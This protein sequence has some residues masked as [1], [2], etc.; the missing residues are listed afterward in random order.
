MGVLMK[1]LL[2]LSVL[3]LFVVMNGAMDATD[4]PTSVPAPG[5]VGGHGG[6]IV[7]T[8]S[9]EPKQP[10][11]VS[12]EFEILGNNKSYLNVLF[13]IT[14]ADPY[15]TGHATNLADRLKTQITHRPGWTQRVFESV[16]GTTGWVIDR[17]ICRTLR[18]GLGTVQVAFDYGV[19][20]VASGIAGV[21]SWAWDKVTKQITTKRVVITLALLATIIGVLE[22]LHR[23]EML[24]AD[25]PYTSIRDLEAH[26]AYLK[27]LLDQAY[28]LK[29][30]LMSGC[31]DTFT[32]TSDTIKALWQKV[33]SINPAM[34][35]SYFQSIWEAITNPQQRLSQEQISYINSLKA[36][37]VDSTV[38]LSY[39]QNPLLSVDTNPLHQTYITASSA[40]KDTV[41][42]CKAIQEATATSGVLHTYGWKDAFAKTCA[43]YGINVF[44]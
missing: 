15:N 25:N 23:N 40:M 31:T 7:P 33:A 39:R 22:T 32:A 35:K 36:A 28:V 20:P 10:V 16:A 11:N 34:A 13:A 5:H 1:K 8:P 41:A 29:D 4:R 3:G 18:L 24:P 26:A 6:G 21:T 14:S 9:P 37:K 17:T 12:A 44:G 19:V 30:S 2:F 27:T 38:S 43:S 42:M